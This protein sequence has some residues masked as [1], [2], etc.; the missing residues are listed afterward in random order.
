MM[1]L[2]EETDLSLMIYNKLIET[3]H[4]WTN[5]ERI[6]PS[7]ISQGCSYYTVTSND[8]PLKNIIEEYT[9]YLFF[10]IYDYSEEC[11]SQE[12]LIY[13]DKSYKYYF[14]C[15]KSDKVF[16]EFTTTNKKITLKEAL[17][18]NYITPNELLDIYP[19]LLIKKK[20]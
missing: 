5:Y 14:D 19:H 9:D 3:I 6:I 13:E 4:I 10:T 18:N 17:N 12:E 1:F 16:I 15:I 11:D 20:K 7:S 2:V 8:N